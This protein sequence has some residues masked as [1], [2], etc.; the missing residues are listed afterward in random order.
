MERTM[1]RFVLALTLC[2]V[3]G[4]LGGCARDQ[5]NAPCPNFGA[6]CSKVPVNSW[7]TH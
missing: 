3:L 5:L 6:S 2:V 4:A 7:D 1:K